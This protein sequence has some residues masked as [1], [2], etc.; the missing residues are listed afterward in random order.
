MGDNSTSPTID[1]PNSLNLSPHLSAQKYFYVCTLT[2]LAWDT[3]VLTPRSYRLGR[4]K[5]WP[6]LKALYYFLQVWV[7]TDFIVTGLFLAPA[8]VRIS[9]SPSGAMFFSTS[10]KQNPDCLQFWPYEPICTAILLF[11]ASAVHVIRVTAIYNHETRIRAL[12]LVLLFVQGVVTAV[13]CGFYRAGSLSTG[14]LPPFFMQPPLLSPVK[15]SIKSL[16]AKRITPWRLM[17]RDNLNLYGAVLIVNLANVL[18]YFIMTP[19]GYDDPIK[20][21]ITSMA[22]VL[23]ATMSMRIVLGVR[24]PLENGGTFSASGSGGTSGASGTLSGTGVAR[25]RGAVT[26]TI[27]DIHGQTKSV[28][29]VRVNGPKEEGHWDDKNSVDAVP[30]RD[31]KVVLPIVGEEDSDKATSA[32]GVQITVNQQVNY[33]ELPRQQMNHQRPWLWTMALGERIRSSCYYY[34]SIPFLL[35]FRVFLINTNP[36]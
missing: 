34:P 24:G 14:S 19:T 20:T 15:R 30:G 16:D 32:V 6:A 2:V 13:C 33:D 21:I 36:S 18:F 23:T 26:Y 11:A 5:A 12:L 10:V 7:L 9:P 31:A 25:A 29:A 1:L 8:L 22:G 4:T 17:L 35:G 27:G 3:L 28:G